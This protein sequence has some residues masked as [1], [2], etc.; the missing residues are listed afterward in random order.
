MSSNPSPKPTGGKQ[1]VSAVR[2]I[3]RSTVK[4]KAPKASGVIVAGIVVCFVVAAASAMAPL[5]F[6]VSH[7]WLALSLLM[8]GIG[9]S[10]VMALRQP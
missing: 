9:V 8:L 10:A 3:P 6:R 2:Q 1:K 4:R 7:W 5:F